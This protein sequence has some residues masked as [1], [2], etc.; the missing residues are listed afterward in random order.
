MLQG[1]EEVLENADTSSRG[2]FSANLFSPA[3]DE[4]TDST[5]SKRLDTSVLKVYMGNQLEL[6]EAEMDYYE[7]VVN[8]LA[9]QLEDAQEELAK[10]TDERDDI[11]S[12]SS[13]L[14]KHPFSPLRCYL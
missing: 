8:K 12:T 1:I 4:M 13:M 10:M 11:L 7:E 14:G 2:R 6:N 9:G 3:K 5:P